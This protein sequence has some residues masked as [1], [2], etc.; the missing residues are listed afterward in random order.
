MEP[1]L[2]AYQTDRTMIPFMCND[3]EKL[4]K[5]QLK[6]FIKLEVIIDKCTSLKQLKEI[7]VRKKKNLL[8]KKKMKIGFLAETKLSLFYNKDLVTGAEVDA[9]KK[10]YGYLLVNLV[11]K[12]P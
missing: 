4:S 6:L 3:L 7:D 9:F 12:I 10:E 2:R 5:N 8:K 1:F 11:E